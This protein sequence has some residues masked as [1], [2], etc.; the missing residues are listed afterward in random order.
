MLTRCVRRFLCLLALFGVAAI[1]SAQNWTPEQQEIWRFE[2]Q[3]WKLA[4]AEDASWVDTMVH[5]NLSFWE[6]AQSAPR[7]KA[8]LQRWNRYSY[9]NSAVL[10]HEIFPVSGVITGN[11]AVVNYTYQVAQE[12]HKKERKMVTGRYTDILGQR[13]GQVVV[14]GLERWRRPGGV[15]P[16]IV[17]VHA[18]EAPRI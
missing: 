18:A 15:I 5:P 1:A 7:N 13:K 9:A 16:A 3:Q 6:T 14:P 11:V 12:D 17:G 10:E 2:E 4:A 8:S